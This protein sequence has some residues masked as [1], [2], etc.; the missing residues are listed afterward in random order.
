MKEEGIQKAPESPEKQTILGNELE[1]IPESK[2][3]DSPDKLPLQQPLI[4]KT[5]DIP[6]KNKMDQDLRAAAASELPMAV[7]PEAT[8]EVKK[9]ENVP[10]TKIDIEQK[11]EMV[12]PLKE[13]KDSTEE[14]K[15]EF[16]A[17][18]VDHSSKAASNRSGMGSH[19]TT[20]Y[21]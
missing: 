9:L 14:N 15:D 6:D 13:V 2:K 21:L 5:K 17:N 20:Y 7:N 16:K 4:D 1:I 3:E 10:P 8:S 11:V 18:S 12:H 19:S